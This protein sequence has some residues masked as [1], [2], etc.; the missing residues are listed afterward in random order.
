M[1]V[2]AGALFIHVAIRNATKRRWNIDT[3]R[4]AVLFEPSHLLVMMENSGY[5]LSDSSSP[6]SP[7]QNMLEENLGASA[8]HIPHT[9]RSWV[10]EAAWYKSGPMQ[11]FASEKS[12]RGRL[13]KLLLRNPSTR[14]G[15]RV[16]DLITKI[17]VCLVYLV[18][19][20]LDDFST[21]QC[22]GFPC[23]ANRTLPEDKDNM[24][25]SS[26]AINWHVLLWV[27]RPFSLWLVQVA[28]AVISLSK[29]VLE[30]SIQSKGTFLEHFTH[31]EFILEI[32]C[33]GLVMITVIYPPILMN[34]FLPTFLSCWLA[35]IALEQLLHDLHLTRQRFQTISV[36]LS[37]QM[38][39]LMATLICLIF[40]TVCGIQ[41]IQRGSATTP[42]TMFEAFYFV[43]VTF[44]TVGYGDI[45][46]DIWLGQL[47]ILLMI[48]VAFIFI[49][50]QI[51]GLATTWIERCKSGGE[52]SGRRAAGSHH[53]VVCSNKL[54]AD[55]IMDFLQEFYAH[56]KLENHVV[57]LLSSEEVDKNLNIILKDPKWA[58]RVIYTR[59]S[60]LKDV[61]LKRCRINDADACFVLAP[62]CESDKEQADHQTILRS[63]A[64]KDF[65]PRCRQYLQLYKM[66]SKLHVKFAEHVVCQDEFKFA[67]LANNC[68]YPGLSTL[69]TLLLHTTTLDECMSLKNSLNWQQIYGRHSSN[70]VYHVQVNRSQIFQNYKNKSFTEASAEAHKNFGVSLVAVLDMAKADPKLILNPGSEYKLKGNDYCF[71][72]GE[73]K[74]EESKIRI[75]VLE[76]V[77]QQEGGK[78]NLGTKEIEQLSVVLNNWLMSNSNAEEE[79]SVFNNTISGELGKEIQNYLRKKNGNTEDVLQADTTQEDLDAIEDSHESHNRVLMMHDDMG[80]E[81]FI[82][83]PPPNNLYAVNC[84]TQCHKMKKPSQLCCLEWGK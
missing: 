72:L 35:K 29:A 76:R 43:I 27:E 71:Y 14:L 58:H 47:F 33:S 69:V 36:T 3:V 46:P 5:V 34:I 73:A 53:V 40:T 80:Q 18:R 81:H 74:E 2:L 82:T 30:L 63:W 38:L 8:D 21:Y 23:D 59:G 84:R 15:S 68:L 20:E 64:I 1:S 50:R 6:L 67:L 45:S 44:S 41:H 60:A 39:I 83:G 32:V 52:Y 16:F 51:E 62:K 48:C 28:F 10:E 54:S 61:D 17:L 55:T 79:E 75:Q 57:V 26:S 9:R 12:L 42:L 25:F 11:Y 66:E 56:P 19:V 31:D 7:L 22:G 13:R 24:E 4:T 65:A 77:L 70:E 37:Q 78:S 49:P